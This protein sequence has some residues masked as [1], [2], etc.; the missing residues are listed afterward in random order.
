M[1]LPE[2]LR[3]IEGAEKVFKEVHGLELDL[4]YNPIQRVIDIL[5]RQRPEM[6]PLIIQAEQDFFLRLNDLNRKLG[7]IGKDRMRKDMVH[8][9][10]Y[11]W[12]IILLLFIII[13]IL[14]VNYTICPRSLVPFYIENIT[15][16]KTSWTY[17]TENLKYMFK[18]SC[19][20]AYVNLRYK[21]N[22]T[23][24]TYKLLLKILN[25]CIFVHY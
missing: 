3:F 2:L 18:K 15:K 16:N 24:W 9:A 20:F 25:L 22:M 11:M 19:A 4:Q 7:V 1:P 5:R 6:D 21:M 13:V 17:S 14:N 12:I 8:K 10:K 23:S